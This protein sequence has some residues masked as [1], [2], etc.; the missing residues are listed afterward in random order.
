VFNSFLEN[1]INEEIHCT[2][3]PLINFIHFYGEV[4]HKTANN[5]PASLAK[6]PEFHTGISIPC[7]FGGVKFGSH[8]ILRSREVL[9]GVMHGV[10]LA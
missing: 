4:K 3:T 10:M 6:I 8:S 5:S 2:C 1:K 7:S 9:H